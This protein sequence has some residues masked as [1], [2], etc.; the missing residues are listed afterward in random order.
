MPRIGFGSKFTTATIGRYV[1]STGSI[2]GS[3]V[4]AANQHA[5]P[6]DATYSTGSPIS[7]ATIHGQTGFR[8]SLMPGFYGENGNG[9]KAN[10]CCSF[11]TTGHGAPLRS[12][13]VQRVVRCRTAWDSTI[14]LYR[15][16]AGEPV[17]LLLAGLQC[18]QMQKA[19]N[20]THNVGNKKLTPA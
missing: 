13:P 6:N 3:G 18:G 19:A 10:L 17:R 1:T 4:A 12:N 2:H 16:D 11:R 8:S 20:A 15:E 14:R 7:S 5:G 9:G